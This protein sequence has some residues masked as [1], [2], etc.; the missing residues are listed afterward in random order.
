MAE[1]D[2][3]DSSPVA[4]PAAPPAKL[5]LAPAAPVAQDVQIVVALL[6]GAIGLLLIAAA[7]TGF[8]G[9]WAYAGVVPA[10]FAWIAIPDRVRPAREAD[11]MA[12]S[13]GLT[14][15]GFYLFFGNLFG[16]FVTF[17]FAPA[18]PW[19]IEAHVLHSAGLTQSI[20]GRITDRPERKGT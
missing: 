14:V 18:V 8:Y 1:P 13:L 6:F 12:L 3:P 15:V 5:A 9:K 10:I 20:S 17:G 19:L 11:M 7:W 2:K 4:R 16:F